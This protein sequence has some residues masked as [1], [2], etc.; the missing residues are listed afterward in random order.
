MPTPLTGFPNGLLSLVGSNNFG[1]APRLLSE[2]VSPVVDVG[3]LYAASKLETPAQSTFTVL[4]GANNANSI[5]VPAGEMWRVYKVSAFLSTG[6]G[7]AQRSVL[8]ATYGGTSLA[9]SGE[10]NLGAS[11]SQFLRSDDEPFWLLAG[12]RL[13]LFSFAP[14]GVPTA[15]LAAFVTRLRV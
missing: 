2:V 15:S 4:N 14:T 6:V 8:I 13:G 10:A 7:E 5:T 9:I 12:G 11:T 1:E 3:E